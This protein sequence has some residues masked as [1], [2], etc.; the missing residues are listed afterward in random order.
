[1]QKGWNWLSIYVSPENRTVP[2]IFEKIADNVISVKSQANGWLMYENG[3]WEGNLKGNLS[4]TEMYAVQ[5]KDDCTLRIVG[6]LVDPATTAVTVEDGWNWI[7]YYGLKVANLADAL[8][9]YGPEDGDILKGQTGVA[10]FDT[11]EWEGSLPMLEPGLGYMLNASSTKSFS[12]PTSV[13][14]R[15]AKAYQFEDMD[16]VTT[17]E[18]ASAFNPVNVHKYPYNAMMSVRLLNG[19]ITMPNTEVGVYAEDECRAKAQTNAQGV[20][21]LTIPG[22]DETTLTFKV[23]VGD[24]IVDA[25]TVVNF[26]ADGVYGTPKNPVIIDID[27]ATSMSEELRGKSEESVYDLS[28]RVVNAKHSTLNSQLKKGVYIING[29]KKAVR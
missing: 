14:A 12:Y 18:E 13:V 20:A 24:Q 5:M 15:Y 8:A 16:E 9:N 1:M 27:E 28:G 26:E 4:N 10:Y 6:T 19:G 11:Y 7:G 22:E 21:Y 25:P 23:A 17:T 3:S 29:Q 2:A